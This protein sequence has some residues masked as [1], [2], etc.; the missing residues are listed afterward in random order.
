[1]PSLEVLDDLNFLLLLWFSIIHLGF[2]DWFYLE[3]KNGSGFF[4]MGFAKTMP[5]VIVWLFMG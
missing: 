2:F 1:M 5:K 4:F 3:Y